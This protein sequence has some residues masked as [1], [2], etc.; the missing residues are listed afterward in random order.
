[1]NELAHHYSIMELRATH[2]RGMILGLLHPHEVGS[3]DLD[4]WR[5]EMLKEPRSSEKSRCRYP[6]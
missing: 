3:L 6:D 5:A 1:M 4:Y 2:I